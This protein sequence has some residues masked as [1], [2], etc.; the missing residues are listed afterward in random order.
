MG[1][2]GQIIKVGLSASAPKKKTKKKDAIL[3]LN[4]DSGLG[5]LPATA[6]GMAELVAP[7]KKKGPGPGAGAKKKVKVTDPLPPVV[8]ASA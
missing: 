6:P 7:K 1:P 4:G 2:L 3:E 8:A 5:L